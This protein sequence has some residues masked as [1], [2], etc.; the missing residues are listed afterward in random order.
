MSPRAEKYLWI[1]AGALAANVIGAALCLL[2]SIPFLLP[3]RVT[4]H[5][6][7]AFWSIWAIVIWPNL[8]LVPMAMGLVAAYFWRKVSLSLLK[9]LLWWTVASVIAPIGAYLVWKEGAVCCLIG[10]PILFGSG[11]T[12]V[13]IGRL[14]FQSSTKLNL[15]IFPLLFLA[16]LVEGKTRENRESVMMDRL[17]VNAPIAEVWKHVIEFPDIKFKPDYWLN[18][19]GLPSP[20]A[21]TCEGAF[22]GADRRCIFSGNLVFEEVVAELIPEKILTFDIVEQPNDPELLGHLTLLRGQF[23]LVDNG[24]N[25]T[26]LIGRSW[27][28]LHMRP[29]WYFDWWTRDVTSHVHLRVMRHIK[30]LSERA[31]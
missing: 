26:T 25:T 22:I 24:D 13:A 3:S 23:E 6:S 19:V 20:L 30:E 2:L 14:W 8:I 27:Y 31:R 4:A 10:F 29:L 28:T 21:T 12:G 7:S 17:S 15:S 9:S 16:I 11:F 18:F 5:S 1:T